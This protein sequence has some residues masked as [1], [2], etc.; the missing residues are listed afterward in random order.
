MPGCVFEGSVGGSAGVTIVST[1]TMLFQ[2]FGLTESANLWR[3]DTNKITTA[4]RVRIVGWRDP[5]GTADAR[6]YFTFTLDNTIW[7]AS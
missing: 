7:G 5:I 4:A 2:E 6:A 1:D 3:I